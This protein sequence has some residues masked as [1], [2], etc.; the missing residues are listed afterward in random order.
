[1]LQIIRVVKSKVNKSTMDEYV[2]HITISID[3]AGNYVYNLEGF[4]EKQTETNTG[5]ADPGKLY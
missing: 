4:D 1:M 3:G 2:N 5:G